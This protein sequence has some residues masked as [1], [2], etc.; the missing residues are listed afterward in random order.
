MSLTLFTGTANP[1]LG[2][3]VADALGVPL[4]RADVS[5]F[6]DGELHVELQETVRGHDVYVLQPTSPPVERHLLEVLLLA[7]ACRRAGAARITGVVPYFG[8]A[9]QDRRAS[10][11]A[12]LGARVV[13]DLIETRGFARLVALDLH[14]PAIEGFF[15]TPLEHL[16]AVPVLVGALGKSRPGNGVVVA[17][18]L[19]ATKLAGRYAK[20]L[21][22]P[23]AIVHKV[24]ESGTDV[25]VR[26]ITG[27][28]H[29]RSPIIVDDMISTGGTIAAAAAALIAAG[30]EPALTVVASHAL[31]V[32]PAVGRL[33]AL[34]LRRL[35][36][37]DSVTLPEV[38]LP[39]MET[40]SVAPLLGDALSRLHHDRSLNDLLVHD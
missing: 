37:S 19:G 26:G 21:M 13:A 31:L 28:V 29:D 18:D 9:R 15:S 22:L 16:T 14:A 11:R 24:R 25:E 30:C 8:Y 23:V 5:C 38:Q 17:P 36:V 7:D 27:D 40:A 4:G 12:A 33:R 32:G 34:R 6:P 3:A 1:A 39:G 35:I 2:Q 20:A 10:G